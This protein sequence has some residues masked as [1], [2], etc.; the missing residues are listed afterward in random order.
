[1]AYMMQGT[2]LLS[3]GFRITSIWAK[4]LI[5]SLRESPAHNGGQ[6]FLRDV[7]VQRCAER[8]YVALCRSVSVTYNID[9]VYYSKHENSKII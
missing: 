5:V 3:L 8:P 4:Y 7:V 2:C 6:P 1:M 9:L